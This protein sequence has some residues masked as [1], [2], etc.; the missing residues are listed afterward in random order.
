MAKNTQNNKIPL[1]DNRC[2]SVSN[3][4]SA[5]KKSH[6]KKWNELHD[7]LKH[8]QSHLLL[9]GE[10]LY[11]HNSDDDF[12]TLNGWNKDNFQLKTGN[13]VGSVTHNGFS[14]EISSR[15]GDDFLKYIIADADGFLHL[16][17]MGDMQEEPEIPWLLLYLWEIKL[18][19][20]FRLG[21]P[22]SYIHKSEKTNK[23]QGNIDLLDYTFHQP[24][25]R[26]LCHFREHSYQNT[27]VGLFLYIYEHFRNRFPLQISQNIY[28]A[29]QVA[30]GGKRYKYSTLFHTPEFSNPYYYD[31]NVVIRLSKM[32]LQKQGAD[33]VEGEKANGFLFDVSMLFEYFI[34][35]F[36]MRNGFSLKSK[37]AEN[38]KIPTGGG[39]Q[40]GYR[41][42][43][44][45]IVFSHQGKIYIY[46]VKYKNFD[47]KYGVKREDLF[48]LHSYIGQYGNQ[49]DLGGCGFIYP[50]SET[51]EEQHKEDDER[52]SISSCIT[53]QGK[54]IPFH[55]F[56]LPIPKAGESFKDNMHKNMQAFLEQFN[57]KL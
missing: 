6:W 39:Y 36:L 49:E 37:L 12:F 34:Y 5:I 53:Q 8:K 43:Q 2:Y 21:L 32:I 15:F 31:Y 11:E 24:S 38:L 23:I 57:E 28:R 56:L 18:R 42:I 30:N 54:D 4:D 45:D 27:A 46:D 51:N 35:K 10:S 17:N 40:G 44:P 33:F 20:A 55:I 19:K 9:H 7:I 48:Q 29:L 50:N 52:V 25:A 41:K 22:K 16:E 1:K 14:V 47:K 26:Y 13:I 3:H